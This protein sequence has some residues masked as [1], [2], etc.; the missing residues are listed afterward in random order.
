MSEETSNKEVTAAAPARNL[1]KVLTATVVSDKQDKTLVVRVDRR[2]AHPL[3][4]K[5][6]KITSKCYVHDENNEAKTG[7]IVEIMETRPLSKLKRWRLV[8]IIKSAVVD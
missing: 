8:K 3:Y 7:D 5:V 1:R 4:R 6:V 2:V